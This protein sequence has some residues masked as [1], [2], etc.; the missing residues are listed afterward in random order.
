MG[1][2]GQDG[3]GHAHLMSSDKRGNCLVHPKTLC[4]PIPMRKILLTPK[5]YQASGDEPAKQ[6]MG[7]YKM[8]HAF[9]L[10]S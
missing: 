6:C 1:I 9:S 5:T 7:H 10:A 8:R 2:I 3:I 4:H